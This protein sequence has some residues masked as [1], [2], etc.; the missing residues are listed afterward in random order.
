MLGTNTLRRLYD[1]AEFLHA[2]S[3]I[4]TA[5]ARAAATAPLRQIDPTRPTSWEFSGFSQNGEDGITDYLLARLA[6]PNRYFVEVGSSDGI[7]NNTAWLAIARRYSGL[8]VEGSKRQADRC[9]RVVQSRALGVQ[10]EQLFVDRENAAQVVRWARNLDP[11]FFSLDI[12]GN[13]YYVAS[14]LLAAGL[15]PKI[16]A[17][18]YN[19]AFGPERA[20]TIAYRPDFDYL[21]AHPQYLYF[22]ASLEAWKKLFGAHGYFFVSTESNGANAYFAD[23]GAFAPPFLDQLR[24]APFRDNYVLVARTKKPWQGQLELLTG[25]ELVEV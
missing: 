9:Q 14:A 18:E 6:A 20:V 12:D 7:E 17:V 2:T 24:P 25:L 1:F 19:A 15:R 23:P 11:D 22:G 10:I 13:D 16:C 5:L 8:M 4:N 21:A 3:R